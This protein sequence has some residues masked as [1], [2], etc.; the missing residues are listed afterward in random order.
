G[1]VQDMHS[2][3]EIY[4]GPDLGWR[5]VEPQGQATTLPEDYGVVLR[6]VLPADEAAAAL[7]TRPGGFSGG[8]PRE[9]TRPG[10]GGFRLQP[11][12]AAHFDGCL[13]CEN[14]AEPTGLLRDDPTP[15]SVAFA[16]ARQK[17]QID[18]A[19]YAAGGI[20]PARLAARRAFLDAR[21]LADVTHILD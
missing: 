4:L 10:D 11:K 5:R 13:G 20:D 17:W 16:H 7:A 1:A 14:L 19:Q 3:D 6:L 18:L 9:L 12:F 2:V 8:P 21:S 15:V